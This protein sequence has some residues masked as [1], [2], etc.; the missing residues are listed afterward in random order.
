MK[1]GKE[2][3]VRITPDNAASMLNLSTQSV[4]LWL[5]SGHCPFGDAFKGSGRSFIYYIN[6]KALND[7]IA[8]KKSGTCNATE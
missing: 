5:Q 3:K 6:E 2:E 8:N 1:K 4:R 7:Y